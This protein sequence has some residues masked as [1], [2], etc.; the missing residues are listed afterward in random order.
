MNRGLFRDGN[1]ATF[2]DGHNSM[3][4]PRDTYEMRNYQPPFDDLPTREEYEAKKNAQGT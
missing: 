4:V 2:T 1:W 3:P